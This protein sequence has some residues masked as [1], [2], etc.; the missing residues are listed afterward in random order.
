MDRANLIL[1]RHSLHLRAMIL[2]Y[3]LPEI[4]VTHMSPDVEYEA[5]TAA[6]AFLSEVVNRAVTQDRKSFFVSLLI[7]EDYILLHRC[8]P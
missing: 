2:E 8:R 5:G 6:L 7:F 3:A 4:V 1:A